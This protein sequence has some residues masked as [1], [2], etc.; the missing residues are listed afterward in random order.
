[1]DFE[2]LISIRYSVRAYKN[3]PVEEWKIEKILNAACLA[4]SAANRQ[5]YKFVV[6]KTEGK[7]DELKK[8][9]SPDWFVQAPVVIAVCGIKSQA[10][11]RSDG[12]NHTD[13]DCAIAMDHLILAATELGLG[14]CWICAFNA[15]EAK[16]ILKLPEDVEPVAFTPLGYPADMP[17]AKKRKSLN[18]I[19]CY[20]TWQD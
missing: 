20:E 8:I 11:K 5:P 14:T 6:I 3:Q 12:K 15:D 10:W 18:Q 13:I 17:K 7:Q 4:P 19:V 1:M 2:K 9:Y 16:K